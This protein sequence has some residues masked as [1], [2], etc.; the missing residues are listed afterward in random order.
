MTHTYR[1]F[2]Q[3]LTFAGVAAA[4]LG[5]VAVKLGYPIDMILKQPFEVFHAVFV[6]PRQR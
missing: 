4:A 5:A 1:P 3:T 2:L 6:A